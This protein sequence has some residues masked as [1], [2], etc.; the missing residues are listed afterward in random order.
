MLKREVSFQPQAIPKREVCISLQKRETRVQQEAAPECDY[1]VSL[2]KRE[3]RV[4]SQEA[5]Y[6]CELVSPH[7]HGFEAVL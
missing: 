1:H 7:P 4:Q 6:K 2:Q 3:V 5:K